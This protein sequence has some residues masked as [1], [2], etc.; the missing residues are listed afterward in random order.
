MIDLHTHSTFSDG[1]LT[2]EELVAS[3]YSVGIRGLALTDHDTTAG[4]PRF[5]AACNAQTGVASLKGVGGVEVSADISCGTLHILGYGVDPHHPDLVQTLEQIREGRRERNEAIAAKLTGL[6][7]PGTLEEARRF[8]R[9]DVLGRPHFAQALVARGYVRSVKEAFDRF[10]ARGRPAYA[11][12]FRFAPQHCIRVIREAGGLAV[13]AHP[14]TLHL[15]SAAL[16]QLVNELK[17]TGLGGL[18]V[19]YSEHTVEQMRQYEALA[20]EFGLVITG[21]TDYHGA[22]TPDI[23][24][25]RGFGNLHIPEHM[26]ENV[27]EAI[28]SGRRSGKAAPG[29]GGATAAGKTASLARAP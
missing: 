18:E 28:E 4:L 29:A 1:T 20:R 10:L 7:M 22:L 17:A 19:Y 12:R 25:G 27:L 2:P 6:G 9:G 13:L 24:L 5:F 23:Q 3:A 21:G 8:S 15:E 16:R 14:F 11:E 26:L